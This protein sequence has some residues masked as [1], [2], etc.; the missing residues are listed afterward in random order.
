[1]KFQTYG[2]WILAGE[3]SVLRGFPALVFPVRSFF[4]EWSLVSTTEAFHVEFS[5]PNGTEVQLLFWGLLENALDRLLLKRSQL[6]GKLKIESHLP[7]G[8]GLGGS[9]ALCVGLAKWFVHEGHL[10]SDQL[11]DFSRG[12]EDI[13]HG[14]SSGVD[15]AAAIACQGISFRKGGLFEAIPMRW[16]PNWFLSFSGKR[17]VTS[18]CVKKVK[19][20][21]SR[22]PEKGQDLDLKMNKA[23]ILALESLN[24]NHDSGAVK[25]R[26][27]L[28]IAC[29]C[30][31]GWDLVSTELDAHLKFLMA[32][33]AIAVK[34][35][36]SGD[37]GYVL[38]L[39]EA[40]PPPE[41]HK[42]LVEIV[43]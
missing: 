2:K 26:N 8:S 5:G 25:L 7:L 34:P 22:N 20:L 28:K 13:F 36:G 37:G 3:H 31:Y 19:E 32:Q 21:L 12:L 38:S 35:T 42:S 16:K 33:G 10:K 6:C 41:I 14:E 23:V 17:G 9:A 15:I 18:E 40:P 1:M 29:E 4:I 27:S 24:E 43:L 11:Y 30:F 39:W